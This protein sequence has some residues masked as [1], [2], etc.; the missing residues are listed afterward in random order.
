MARIAIPMPVV[1][2]I[3]DRSVIVPESA[4]L[5]GMLV[6]KLIAVTTSNDCSATYGVAGFGEGFC[7][8]IALTDL[9]IR[10]TKYRSADS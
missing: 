6:R 5:V 10:G 3:I 2:L 1:I 7:F 8:S 9:A 4:K